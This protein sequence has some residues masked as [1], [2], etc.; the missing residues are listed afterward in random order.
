MEHLTNTWRR[1]RPPTPSP[2]ERRDAAG[3][4]ADAL[5][6]RWVELDKLAIEDMGLTAVA[7]L[8]EAGYR[9]ERTEG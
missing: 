2:G 5:G 6:R 1:P 8:E 9:L 7:A 4:I 3:A